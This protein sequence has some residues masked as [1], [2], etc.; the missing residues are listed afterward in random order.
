MGAGQGERERP[1]VAANHTSPPICTALTAEVGKA[2]KT[3]RLCG[4]LA[5]EAPRAGNDMLPTASST[6]WG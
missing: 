5:L 4:A 6:S 3:A 2:M 1:C